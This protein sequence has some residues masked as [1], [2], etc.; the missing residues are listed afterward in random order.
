[1]KL[2][3]IGQKIRILR[4]KKTNSRRTCKYLWNK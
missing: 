4:E 1:M 2:Y 3:E